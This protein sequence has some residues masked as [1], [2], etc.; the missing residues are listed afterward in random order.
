MYELFDYIVYCIY[1]SIKVS[2]KWAWI[3][4]TRNSRAREYNARRLYAVLMSMYSMVIFFVT[5]CSINGWRISFIGDEPS[6][7]RMLIYIAPLVLAWVTYHYAYRRYT[8]RRMSSVISKHSDKITK[9]QAMLIFSIMV[10]VLLSAMF[11]MW[12]MLSMK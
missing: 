5:V 7:I 2:R 8:S 1:A 6:S 3:A 9:Q 10:V 12:R 4:A 11:S